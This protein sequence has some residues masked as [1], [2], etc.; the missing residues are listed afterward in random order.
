MPYGTPVEV[1]ASAALTTAASPE[2][3]T[4]Q[5]AGVSEALHL[6]LDVTAKGGT[7]PS[8]DVQIE[9]SSDDGTTWF[10]AETAAD[11]AFAQLADPAIPT[12]VAKS[13]TV[14]A[15]WYRLISTVAG[16]TGTIT[17]AVDGY[18]TH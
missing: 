1:R 8:L 6:F 10:T 17:F 4:K 5:H 11:D 2:T 14:R 7:T 16:V 9:W 3:G 12:T 13:F 18:L 15:P